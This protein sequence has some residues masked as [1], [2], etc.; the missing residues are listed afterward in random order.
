MD[1]SKVSDEEWAKL[2]A[3]LKK[4]SGIRM[5]CEAI[6]R[7]FV[8]AV[9]WILRAGAQWRLLPDRFER[10]NSVFK[11]FA[12]LMPVWSLGQGARSCISHG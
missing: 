9:L 11:R 10:W 8:H 3:V 12:C 1:K 4:I 5:G 7:R 2:A 6:C